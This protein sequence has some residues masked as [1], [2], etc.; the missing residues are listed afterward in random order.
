MIPCSNITKFFERH[1]CPATFSANA[2]TWG[3]IT[4]TLNVEI[5]TRSVAEGV[6][7]ELGYLNQCATE[8]RLRREHPAL[9]TAYDEYQLLL[10]L[11]K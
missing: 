9:K 5:H 2:S 11:I 1:N 4:L 10:K 7:N 6:D 8:A 3:S